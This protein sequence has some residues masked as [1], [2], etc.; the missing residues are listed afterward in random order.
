MGKDKKGAPLAQAL[1]DFAARHVVITGGTGQLGT[2]VTNAFL[3]RGATVHIPA[4]NQREVDNFALATH[5]RIHLSANINLTDE[6]SVIKFYASLPPLWASVH[7]A[8]GF[9]MS[10]LGETSKD[11][12]MHQMNM[13]ALTTFL[14]CREAATKMN[15]G[16]GRI[17]NIAARPALEPRT[18]AGMVAYTAAKAAVSAMT[19]AI[20][21]ELKTKGIL[22]NA[23]VPSILDTPTNR[24]DMPN[25][26]FADWP[27]VEE[28]S[29]TIIF[30]ASPQNRVTR[31]SL[32]TVYGRS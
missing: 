29:E 32:V 6:Q 7:I 27:T 30:L 2:S 26:N 14:C 15:Q 3:A 19:Q 31:S 13:N 22:V 17:V 9:A 21:E 20:G 28:V 5:E 24:K 11:D 18:G 25:A 4:F 16:E 8:G 10:A 12:F 1:N 23:V